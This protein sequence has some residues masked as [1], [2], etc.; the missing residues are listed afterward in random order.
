M[1]KSD[2]FY[3]YNKNN[4]EKP[5]QITFEVWENFHPGIITKGYYSKYISGML[6]KDQLSKI[7]AFSRVYS[8]SLNDPILSLQLDKDGG[9]TVMYQYDDDR[10]E[11]PPNARGIIAK[12]IFDKNI[13][14][15]KVAN[16]PGASFVFHTSINSP[17]FESDV[18]YF[19][20]VIE[21]IVSADSFENIISEVEEIKEQFKQKKNRKNNES[22][23]HFSN[24][25]VFD[26]RINV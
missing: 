20:S 1:S 26:R 11:P 12:P 2:K 25:Y 24:I 9:V 21:K 16:E 19:A 14:T 18:Y 3:G 10:N 13:N 22:K 8:S 23:I 15:L 5:Y 17:Q 4:K 6:A 7:F